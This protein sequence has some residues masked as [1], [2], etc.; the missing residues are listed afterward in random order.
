MVS[1][2]QPAIFLPLLSNKFIEEAKLL[3]NN[4]RHVSIRRTL[5]AIAG[6]DLKLSITL[7]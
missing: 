7:T 6:V 3:V 5:Y 2:V 4:T 1:F